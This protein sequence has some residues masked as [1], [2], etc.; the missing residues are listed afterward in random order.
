MILMARREAMREALCCAGGALVDGF[1]AVFF[2]ITFPVLIR[3][4]F[5]FGIFVHLADYV[6]DLSKTT[7]NLFFNF[8]SVLRICIST[9][10][11]LLTLVD[12]SPGSGPG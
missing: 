5:C 7:A 3:D 1:T 9:T 4:F 12:H 10:S 2:E 11:R 8:G 6:E